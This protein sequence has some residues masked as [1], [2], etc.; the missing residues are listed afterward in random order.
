MNHAL[1]FNVHVFGI[2]RMLGPH[3]IA[4][5]LREHEWNVEV[6]DWAS[7][8]S[9]DQLKELARLRITNDTKFLGFGCFFGHWDEKF[10]QYCT[11]IKQHWPDIKIVY[12][13]HSFPGFESNDVDYYVV[14]YGEKAM[15]E[16]VR[17]F[18]GNNVRISY[19]PR[20]FGSKKLISAIDTYPAYPMRSLKVIYEDRDF[21][22]SREWLTT[23]LSRGCKFECKFCNFPILGVKGDYSRDAEDFDLQL[24]DTYDRFGITNYYLAD[25][26][27]NDT[28]EK[29]EKFAK[30][31]DRLDFKT[32]IHGF[33]RADLLVANKN[34]W[35]PIARLG[36]VGHYYG[37]ETMNKKSG[38][39]IGKGMDPKKLMPGLLEVQSWFKK[40]GAYRGH[41]SLICGLPHETKETWQAGID[42]VVN[43]WQGESANLFAL[44]I[45]LN[46][47][48]AKLSFISKNYESLGYR[49][50]SK[51]RNKKFT[52]NYGRFLLDWENDH[53]SLAE[54]EE[55]VREGDNTIRDVVGINPWQFGDFAF[56]DK[57]YKEIASFNKYHNPSPNNEYEIF[58]N[59]YIE[60]KLNL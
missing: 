41:I 56:L 42:W 32:T 22:D 40:Y 27:I 5:Y 18:T 10:D 33:I 45:P 55:L 21:L 14:G 46:E 24:R 38:A 39:S 23:E 12:G 2:R 60:K 20:F 51:L 44:D 25:E 49:E 9:L 53:M 50:T 48:D 31:T 15:L 59:A 7:S 6:I 26:T 17:S 13:S 19:D 37:I 58:I 34:Q 29:L 54:A 52:H 43:N 30:V 4:S 16:L 8:W 28:V 11:W 35:D 1:M 3:R 57:T 47:M 36:L